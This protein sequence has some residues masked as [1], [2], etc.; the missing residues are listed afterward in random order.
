MGGRSGNEEV[1]DGV[2]SRTRIDKV[3]LSNSTTYRAPRVRVLPVVGTG[4]DK[5]SLKVLSV[6]NDG[7]VVAIIVSVHLADRRT[8]QHI[9]QHTIHVPI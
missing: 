7:P 9:S 5:R 8:L 4:I 3:I 2:I 6:N 1:S